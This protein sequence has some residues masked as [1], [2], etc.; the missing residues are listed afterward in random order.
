MQD[1]ADIGRRFCRSVEV[2]ISDIEN[3]KSGATA[4]P[5]RSGRSITIRTEAPIRLACNCLANN[6]SSLKYIVFH[7]YMYYII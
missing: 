1:I 3:S 2:K 6:R 7:T 4:D 5:H